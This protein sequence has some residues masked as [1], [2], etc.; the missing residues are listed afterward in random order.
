MRFNTKPLRKIQLERM[1]LAARKNALYSGT[2]DNVGLQG[3]EGI[4]VALMNKASRLFSLVVKNRD[5]YAGEQNESLRDTLLD[6]GNYADFGVALL[7]D[8]WTDVVRIDRGGRKWK[9]KSR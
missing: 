2:I 6:A 8:T 5:N 9:P 4:A 3:L 1:R 7:D